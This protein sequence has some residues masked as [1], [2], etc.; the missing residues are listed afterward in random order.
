LRTVNSKV[1]KKE[2]DLYFVDGAYST[3]NRGT[4]SLP[5]QARPLWSG[6]SPAE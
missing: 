6:N 1:L 5:L 4:N 2:S 3:A